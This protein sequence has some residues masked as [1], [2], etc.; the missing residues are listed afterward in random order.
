[1]RLTLLGVASTPFGVYFDPAMRGETIDPT[2]LGPARDV[3]GRLSTWLRGTVGGKGNKVFRMRLAV[4]AAFVLGCLFLGVQFARFTRAAMAGDLPLPTRPPGVE[5]FLPISGLMGLFDWAHQ[6]TLNQVHPAATMLFV[7]IVA[8]AFFVRKSFCSW[9]CPVGFLSEALARFGRRLFGRNFRPW[10]WID[11]PLRGLKYLVL[12]FFLQAVVRMSDT[13]LRAFIES[14]Y[15]RVADVKMGLFFLRL[16]EF[17]AGVMLTL[18]VLSVFINGAWCRY[19]CP[20]GALLG[21]VS[22]VSPLKVHR[23]ADACIDCGL[24]DQACMARL[25]V[26]QLEQVTSA[27]CT[28]CLD[29]VASCPV[30]D[31]LHVRAASRWR[32]SLPAYALAILLLFM[33]GYAGSR[34]AGLWESGLSDAEYSERIQQLDHPDYGH[35]GS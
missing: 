30:T 15:N 5:G 1:V 6:G 22:W 16:G 9:I 20:Y 31:A 23:Q 26:S 18:L 21:L 27:E 10:K 14:P 4:Q 17:G 12:F 32:L 29:C 19:L 13:A 8:V 25:P 28:G 34:L 33:G 3:A 35:P 24:C 2:F 7:I 11:I